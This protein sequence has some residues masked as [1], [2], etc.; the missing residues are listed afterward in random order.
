[1]DLRQCWNSFSHYKREFKDQGKAGR[2]TSEPG[3]WLDY[4]GGAWITRHWWREG[5]C[6]SLPCWNVGAFGSPDNP[7]IGLPGM[8]SL[9][10][11]DGLLIPAPTDL[12]QLLT[13]AAM[14]LLP[15]IQPKI[16][17]INS[18]LELK[19][20]KSIG[21]TL[22]SISKHVD[23]LQ[24]LKNLQTGESF[25]SQFSQASM[26]ELSRSAGDI[27]LQ[28]KF[29]IAPLLSDVRGL[30]DT[31]NTA[32]KRAQRLL[33]QSA[34]VITR[35][36]TVTIDDSYDSD[37]NANDYV[38]DWH[39]LEIP[40]TEGGFCAFNSR[41]HRKVELVPAKF[42]VELQFSYGYTAFQRQNAAF[43]TLLDRVGVNFDPAILWNATPWSFVADW[44]VGFGQWLGQFRRANM[45]PVI[46]I[47]KS[48]WSIERVRRIYCSVD[49]QLNQGVPTSFVQETAYRR[50]LFQMTAHSLT[51]SGLS[52][53]ETSLGLALFATRRR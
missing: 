21:S 8:W 17:L 33:S 37:P 45:E 4:A 16:S 6:P 48:L 47:H 44:V 34:R 2:V 41:S 12:E 31:V 53:T 38:S 26:N 43:L 10:E 22:G 29:N 11:D 14:H 24:K 9:D 49:M 15:G 32:E 51:T 25:F 35:H 13:D 1:V 7:V 46:V 39:W 40:L 23:K 50:Q 27:Y 3:S 36:H 42:H 28:Y 19:D 52:L 30:Q 20:I 18:I 5:N